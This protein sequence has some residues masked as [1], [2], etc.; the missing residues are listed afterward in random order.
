MKRRKFVLTSLFASQFLS[1]GNIL[2]SKTKNKGFKVNKGDGRTH[3]HILLK[4]VNENILDVKI[5]GKDTDGGFAMFEQTSLSPKRGTPLHIHYNQDESF[6]VL[7]GEYLFQVGEDI[8]QLR[9]GD[10]IFLPKNIP[11]AWSQVGMKGRMMVIFQPAGKMENFFLKLS[12]LQTVP[13][14]KQIAKIF[15]EHEMKIIGPPLKVE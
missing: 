9:E 13:T 11:H 8:F 10:T 5:S 7:E 12:S 3:G 6:H 4:G 2:E 1:P 15:E 14:P